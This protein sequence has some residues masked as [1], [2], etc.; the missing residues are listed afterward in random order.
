MPSRIQ[1]EVLPD[2]AGLRG[3][4][5]RRL[6]HSVELERARSTLARILN[7]DEGIARLVDG[8][9]LLQ[10]RTRRRTPSMLP[11]RDA[12]LWISTRCPDWGAWMI[13]PRPM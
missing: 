13:R 3:Q 8:L 12:R 6:G 10:A 1:I 9:H 7:E 11:L 4:H 2:G 5:S